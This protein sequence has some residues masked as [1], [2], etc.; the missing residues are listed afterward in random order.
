MLNSLLCTQQSSFCNVSVP[1]NLLQA[2]TT[3]LANFF[4]NV[5]VSV[6]CSRERSFG[7]WINVKY[8][9][10]CI[11]S[12]AD[13]CVHVCITLQGFSLILLLPN[14][15]DCFGTASSPALGTL[16][17]HYEPM[18][19]NIICVMSSHKNLHVRFNTT[20]RSKYFVQALLPVSYGR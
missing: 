4:L 2:H 11:C 16:Q 7:S 6:F 3:S 8:E 20:C 9:L 13:D 12:R 19:H 10:Y 1:R 15:M 5:S 18:T 14:V 17:S